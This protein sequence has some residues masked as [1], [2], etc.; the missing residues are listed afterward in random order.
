M[1]VQMELRSTAAIV[2]MVSHTEL[3]GFVSQLGVEGKKD[4]GVVALEVRGVSIHRRLA[5]PQAGPP[6]LACRAGLRGAP[7]LSARER[8][9]VR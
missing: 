2:E 6:A 1:N 8:S 7:A 9:S 4:V 5:D 3:L